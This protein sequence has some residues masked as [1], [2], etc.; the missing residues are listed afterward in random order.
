M[1]F[2]VNF[3]L[4]SSNWIIRG[5]VSSF[6]NSSTFAFNSV[7]SVSRVVNFSLVVLVSSDKERYRSSKSAYFSFISLS[8]WLSWSAGGSSSS[9]C[10]SS[11]SGLSSPSSPCCCCSGSPSCSCFSSG[12]TS[13]SSS[14][15]SF[16]SSSGLSLTSSS[17]DSCSDY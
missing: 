5:F 7:F 1:S 10:S 2:D 11:P 14:G 6:D 9:C 4:S 15:L 3:E 16:T 17:F 13:F 12:D 8:S